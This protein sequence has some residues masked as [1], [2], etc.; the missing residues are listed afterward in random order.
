MNTFMMYTDIYDRNF[1]ADK[2]TLVTCYKYYLQQTFSE[3]LL[4]MQPGIENTECSP[5]PQ[6]TY[7]IFSVAKIVL[8]IFG[9]LLENL[10]ISTQPAPKS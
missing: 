10:N 7:S 4:T 9:A 6:L 1:V 8:L 3:L 5:Y 2:V